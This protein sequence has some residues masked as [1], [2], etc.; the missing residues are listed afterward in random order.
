M[1]SLLG[2]ASLLVPTAAVASGGGE[3]EGGAATV[4]WEVF[5][6]VLLIFVLFLAARRP[7]GAYLAERK[8]GVEQNIQGAED[9]LKEAEARLAQWNARAA[10]LEHEV[11][12]IKSKAHAA[13]AQEAQRIVA[14][15]EGI[16]QRIRAEAG[17][18]V[19]RE[20]YRGR[21]ALRR[22][23]ADLAVEMAEKLLREEV[24]DADRARLVEE[25]VGRVEEGA[26]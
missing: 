3:A 1:R 7:V 18:A 21:M 15:A 23:A 2:V 24:T 26:S 8:A 19:E 11:A 4:A 22:E 25:F 6:L 17:A 13:A 5:N 10:G 14:E 20:T 9:V 16:A 12:D